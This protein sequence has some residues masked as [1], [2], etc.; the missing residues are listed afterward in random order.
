[1]R[2]PLHHAP[3]GPCPGP[4]C[5]AP[6][7]SLPEGPGLCD[8]P[9]PTLWLSYTLPQWYLQSKIMCGRI[10]FPCLM[11]LPICGV[12]K[13]CVLE[14]GRRRYAVGENWEPA[15]MVGT[16]GSCSAPG[17]HSPAP[18]FKKEAASWTV[19]HRPLQ[20]QGTNQIENTHQVESSSLLESGSNLSEISYLLTESLHK[21]PSQLN[22]EFSLLHGL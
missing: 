20:Q 16:W 1:M 18:L 6:W 17:I 7:S 9:L 21:F 15:W 11:V 4:P 22:E 3:G 5:R 14:S 19:I 13:L 8:I 10:S 12:I 2:S